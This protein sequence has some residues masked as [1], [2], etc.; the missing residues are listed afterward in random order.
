[1][2]FLTFLVETGATVNRARAYDKGGKNSA[3]GLKSIA[4]VPQVVAQVV[5]QLLKNTGYQRCFDLNI[6]VLTPEIMM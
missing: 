2:S 4:F 3:S 6:R 1:L 5:A